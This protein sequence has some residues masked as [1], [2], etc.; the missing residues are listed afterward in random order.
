MTVRLPLMFRE[1]LAS[2]VNVPG[3]CNEWSCTSKSSNNNSNRTR[4]DG[5]GGVRALSA[6]AVDRSA[7][8]HSYHGK[9][10]TAHAIRTVGGR[11]YRLCCNSLCHKK[12]H[13]IPDSIRLP[14]EGH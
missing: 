9:I 1:V 11:C 5:V 8:A 14:E 12:H 13:Y 10:N 4:R 3:N 2:D 7:R 6:D